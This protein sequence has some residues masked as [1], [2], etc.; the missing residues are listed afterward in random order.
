[1][2]KLFRVITLRVHGFCENL[3]RPTE[4]GSP[5]CGLNA[6][7]ALR[8]VLRHDAAPGVGHGAPRR[9]AQKAVDEAGAQ[10]TPE[11]LPPEPFSIDG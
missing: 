5:T 2:R 4:G 10:L 1:M 11:H 3:L 8:F 7:V 9:A 6:M